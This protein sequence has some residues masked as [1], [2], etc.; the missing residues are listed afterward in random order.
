MKDPWPLL[1]LLI[2]VIPLGLDLG[3]PG[4]PGFWQ[5]PFSTGTISTKW[6]LS[7]QPSQN[8]TLMSDSSRFPSCPIPFAA[9][10]LWSNDLA[11]PE[12]LAFLQSEDT[13]APTSQG[14][15]D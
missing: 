9:V 1:L 3:H 6:S 14:R 11:S 4:L 2:G 7:N 12:Q 15:Q 10:S 5:S 8:P 13:K